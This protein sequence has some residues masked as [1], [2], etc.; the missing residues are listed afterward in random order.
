MLSERYYYHLLFALIVPILLVGF[1]LRVNNLTQYPP[2]I[3]NDE[4]VN[5][6]DAFHIAKTGN[7]PMYEED[8]G[9]AE[10]LFRILE[11]GAVLAFGR[12][13]WILRLL[14]V[15]L[16]MFTIASVIWVTLEILHDYPPN[17]RLIGALGAGIVIATMAGH[18]TLSRTL[19]RG[20]LQL[21]TMNL[22]IGFVLHGLRT[23][24]WQDF[25][26]SGLWGGITLYTYTAAWFFPPVFVVL[27]A[28]LI[29]FRWREWPIYLPRILILGIVALLVCLPLIYLVINHPR[30]VFGRAEALISENIFSQN[31]I[32]AMIAQFLTHGDENPQYNV[33]LKPVIPSKAQILFFIGLLALFIRVRKP[34]SWLIAAMFILMVLPAFLSNE[35]THGLRIAGEYIVVSVIIGL[36]IGLVL[37]IGQHFIKPIWLMLIGIMG[38]CFLLIMIGSDTWTTYVNY[39]ENPSQ[40][41]MWDVHEMRLDQ[42]DWFYRADRQDFVTWVV[43]Q[44]QALLLPVEEISQQITHSLLMQA[45]PQVVTAKQDFILPENTLLVVPWELGRGDLIRDTRDYALLYENTITILPPISYE[46]QQELLDDIETREAILREEGQI[47]FLGYV[48]PIDRD[49]VVFAGSNH[50]SGAALAGFN[51]NEI[52]VL[53]W[54][55]SETIAGGETIDISLLW[56]ANRRVGHEYVNFLQIQTQDFESVTGHE[57]YILRWL[58]PSSIWSPDAIVP[59]THRLHLPDQLDA[60]AYRL[61]TGLYYANQRRIAVDDAVGGSVDNGATIAWLKVP[62]TPIEIAENALPVDATINDLFALNRIAFAPVE[63]QLLAHVYWKSLTH[64]PPVDATIFIH[65]VDSNGQIVA[66]SDLRPMNGQYPTFIWDE[67][68]IVRTEHFLPIDVSSHPDE[69]TV[70]L[71]MYIFVPEPQNLP[72]IYN[73]EAREDGLIELGK[74]S[75][76]MIGEREGD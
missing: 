64:R 30:A 68:E 36:G 11:A 24:Q 54:Y 39:W 63:G 51:N 25:A 34:S 23:N 62:Q 46:S 65:I 28:S 74:L 47:N 15:I 67:D 29:I 56:R 12:S 6:L 40:Q 73:G 42:N 22:A 19:F 49:S 21:L 71:G 9:R 4:A 55:G 69:Y 60:G 53:D 20:I 50:A 2:S 58:Y 72:L 8:E 31:R 10:P 76:W 66:Q 32:N 3:S 52:M 37:W 13:I 41:R 38:L 33:A 7:F 16:S 14:T 70:R 48:K 57:D 43:G 75:D 18:V 27:G 5:A 44:K 61:V 35:I 59:N 1:W 26:L 45:Y 17:I